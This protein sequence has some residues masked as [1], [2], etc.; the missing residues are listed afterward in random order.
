MSVIHALGHVWPI[1]W[2]LD[3]RVVH[4]WLEE[5][6]FN[7]WTRC[8]LEELLSHLYSQNSTWPV[9]SRHGTLS[10]WHRKKLWFALWRVLSS[11]AW[12]VCLEKRDMQDMHNA[13]SISTSAA[14]TH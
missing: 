12:H 14:L 5:R 7:E 4:C 2:P 13:R 10:F 3:C 8:W 6:Q 11:T 9:T 1:I